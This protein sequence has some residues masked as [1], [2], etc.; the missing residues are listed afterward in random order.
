MEKALQL[1]DKLDV[2]A[3]SFRV[4]ISSS[5]DAITK[6]EINEAKRSIVQAI[7]T[8]TVIKG[9]FEDMDGIVEGLTEITKKRI[10]A[11]RKDERKAA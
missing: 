7:Q 11:S 10:L 5:Y 9:L 4:S 1:V 8:Q 2:L 3:S 6:N